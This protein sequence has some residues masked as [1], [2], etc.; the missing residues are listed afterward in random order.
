MNSMNKPLTA[1]T[2]SDLWREVK[3]EEED[4]WGDLKH[5]HLRKGMYGNDNT[6][7]N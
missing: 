3:V 7:Y 6:T 5:Q 1:L 2:E 4:I